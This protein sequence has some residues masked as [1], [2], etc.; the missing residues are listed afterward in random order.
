[1][2]V[3]GYEDDQVTIMSPDGELKED[4]NF[5]TEANLSDLRGKINTIVDAGEKEIEPL[6]SDC[7]IVIY[8][9]GK[10]MLEM[11]MQKPDTAAAYQLRAHTRPRSRGEQEK[12]DQG[13][14]D[15]C[16][17]HSYPHRGPA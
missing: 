11:M 9:F 14:Q 2:Q 15:T 16:A 1:M 4:F 6:R 7:K 3:I 17:R 12:G 8:A 5:P 13:A 10:C